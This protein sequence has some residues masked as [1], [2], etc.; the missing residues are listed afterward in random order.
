[1]AA[2]APTQR[3]SPQYVSPSLGP[4]NPWAQQ[5]STGT[6]RP[7]NPSFSQHHEVSGASTSDMSNKYSF[8]SSNAPC[9]CLFDQPETRLHDTRQDSDYKI[10]KV[11]NMIIS[12]I[13][14]EQDAF[15]IQKESNRVLEQELRQVQRRREETERT[16]REVESLVNSLEKFQKEQLELLEE[17]QCQ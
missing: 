6:F 13:G 4:T 12:A 14:Q 7:P 17:F 5:I 15:A 10:Q 11:M 3:S 2:S 1:M 9:V 8:S 16:L